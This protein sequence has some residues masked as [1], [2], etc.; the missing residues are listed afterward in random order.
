M[1]KIVNIEDYLFIHAA[2]DKALEKLRVRLRSRRR[3]QHTNFLIGPARAGK[4]KT[5]EKLCSDLLADGAK[6][7]TM[8]ISSTSAGNFNMH[9]VFT[10]LAEAMGCP[11]DGKYEKTD[12][13]R[14]RCVQYANQNKVDYIIL[15]DSDVLASSSSNSVIKKQ[16]DQIKSLANAC[17]A[18]F[19]FVG[20]GALL[21][22]ASKF[23]QQFLRSSI[24]CIEPYRMNV[25]ADRSVFAQCVR[26]FNKILEV[27]LDEDLVDSPKYL[28]QRSGGLIGALANMLMDSMDMAI[29]KGEETLTRERIEEE[30]Y[31]VSASED[32]IDDIKLI[33]KFVSKRKSA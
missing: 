25:A 15:D 22:L 9:T 7:V 12:F 16:A 1:N 19:L 5:A 11:L 17:N 3:S 14:D 26:R 21:N 23:G 30:T 6:V 2:Q 13:L 32:I 10:H 28:H 24:T 4:S 18:K 27:P 8:D 29:Y 20:T 31:P 33:H